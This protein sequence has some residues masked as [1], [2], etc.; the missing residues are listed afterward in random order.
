ME[1]PLTRGFPGFQ[2]QFATNPPAS[3]GG[4]LESG[5]G[6]DPAAALRREAREEAHVETGELIGLGH[7]HDDGAPRRPAP[8]SDPDGGTDHVLRP[9][10][11]RPRL[12]PFLCPPSGHTRAD[13][14]AL[15]LG[16]GR[17]PPA[18]RRSPCPRTA[19]TA[20]SSPATGLGA[21]A[22]GGPAVGGSRARAL[23]WC[24]H[25]RAPG[26]EGSAAGVG[27]WA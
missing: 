20:R 17:R 6:G 25:L 5:D 24:A 4:T 26:V 12:R 22:G 10:E 13:Q 14:R 2:L 23:C 15:R 11:P 16:T 3:P 21:A 19:R 1:R 27:R 9:R 18:R 8:G 7:L